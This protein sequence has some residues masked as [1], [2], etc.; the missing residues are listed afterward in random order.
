MKPEYDS[1]REPAKPAAHRQDEKEIVS[2]QPEEVQPVHDAG[3]LP[4]LTVAQAEFFG[5]IQERF[6]RHGMALTVTPD[7]EM[8]AREI[9]GSR[10][11]KSHL[12]GS[13]HDPRSVFSLINT[14]YDATLSREDVISLMFKLFPRSTGL[15][16]LFPPKGDY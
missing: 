12:S 9:G 10:D 13:I 5:A 7:G 6:W 15:G 11:G 4:G 8:F 16:F 3:P 1:H 14:M 2:M